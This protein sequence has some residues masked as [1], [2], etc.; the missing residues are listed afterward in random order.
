MKKNKFLII[1][2]IAFYLTIF[3]ILIHNSFSY[4]DPD[5]GWHLKVGEQ[6]LKER[7]LPETDYYTYTYGGKFWLDIEWLSNI[8]VYWVYSKLGNISLNI[9]F[10]LLII[11]TLIILKLFTQKYYKAK[12]GL[13]YFFIA[14]FQALGILAC[15][16]HFGVR[17][18]E[19]SVLNTLLLLFIIQQYNKSKNLKILLFIFP[20]FY[21][22][23]SLHGGFIIGIFIMFF[24]LFVKIIEIISSKIKYFYFIDYN[25]KLKF[26][27]LVIFSFF[28]SGGVVATLIT[29]YGIKLYNFL[30][31][32]YKNDF[33]LKQIQEWLPFYYLPINYWQILFESILLVVIFL[34]I[35]YSVKKKSYKIPLWE[36]FLSTFL[37]VFALKSKRNFPLLFISSFPL[38]IHFLSFLLDYS[39]NNFLNKKWGKPRPL[40]AGHYA[41]WQNDAKSNHESRARGILGMGGKYLLIVKI[42]FIAGLLAIS[43]TKLLETKIVND[44]FASFKNSYPYEAV[45]FLKKHSEYNSL[46]LFS[47]YN[48][49]GYLVWMLPEKK[50]FISGQ[51]PQQPFAG[52]TL[53][54]E[55]LEFYK[56]ERVKIKLDQYNINLVLINNKKRYIKLN[57]F[58]KYFLY[59]NEE[60]INNYENNLKNYLDTSPS[61]QL[62]YSDNLSNIYV[63]KR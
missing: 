32:H 55:Y 41:L 61:W 12:G 23:S 25:N 22:W 53:L 49:G 34:A 30:I 35:F 62:A 48:W 51:L 27:Q 7:A 40:T 63:R 13:G 11:I 6:I 29:P 18:Q 38:I 26:K 14:F 3:A 52:R 8:L 43:A 4:L 50:L 10:V 33:Y 36:I 20:L 21:F 39:E 42:Y 58:E 60:E 24:W 2:W 9:L 19:I 46:K 37:L 47:E 31:Y 1:F 59:L 28:A 5:L 54:E 44:P 16:P 45:N 57:W 56:K 15:L 17:E